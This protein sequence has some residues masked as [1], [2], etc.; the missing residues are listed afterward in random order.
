MTIRPT[1]HPRP[2]E[3]TV[4]IPTP[5]VPRMGIPN[6]PNINIP[7]PRIFNKLIPIFTNNIGLGLP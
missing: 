3:I 2:L 5:V 4:D 6:Q 7:F 1:M